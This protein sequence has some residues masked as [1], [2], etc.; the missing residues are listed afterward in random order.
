MLRSASPLSM[1]H[2]RPSPLATRTNL[3]ICKYVFKTYHLTVGISKAFV[4]V[5]A[6]CGLDSHH[7]TPGVG[8]VGKT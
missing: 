1:G 7:V 5:F 8:Y 4:I 3:F 2:L 6:V